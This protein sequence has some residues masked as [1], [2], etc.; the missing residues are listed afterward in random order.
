M[1]LTNS[2]LKRRHL[3]LAVGIKHERKG[4]FRNTK[5]PRHIF[6][7]ILVKVQLEPIHFIGICRNNIVMLIVIK[8]LLII[9]PPPPRTGNL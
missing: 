3:Y 1:I 5:E 7:S 6:N 2:S 8:W 4:D 9:L